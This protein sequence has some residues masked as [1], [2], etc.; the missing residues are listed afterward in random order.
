MPNIKDIAARAN[1]S[2][3]TVSYVLNG[4]KSVSEK[5]RARVLQIIEEMNYQPNLVAKSLKLK[6]TQTIGV[7]VEDVTSFNSSEIIDGIHEYAEEQGFSILLTNIRVLK[8]IDHFYS[9]ADRV[10]ELAPPAV[11]EIVNKQVDGLIYV[12][13]HPRDVTGLIPDMQIPIVYSYCYTNGA[14]DYSVNYDDYQAAYES[15][16]YLIRTGHKKIAVI[17]GVMDSVPTKDRFNG[18]YQALNDNNLIFD[19]ALIKTGDWEYESG[20]R[21]A[22]ELL[23]MSPCPDAILAMNDN[24]A[25]GA[26]SAC[27]SLGIKVPDDIS[28][29]GFDDREF[30]SYLT[31]SLTTMRLPL[32]EMGIEAI[33]TLISV[34]NEDSSEEHNKKLS[35]KLIER[36]SV[37]KR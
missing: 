10:K 18:Y 4:K 28:V 17:S 3:A 8:R 32:H 5:T 21:S 23:N 36:R 13:V 30:S 24:M 6:R 22:L 12:G 26:V 37:K 31:P 16:E 27:H 9:K 20:H 2:T 11:K 35:C 1:V 7:I 15:T 14:D 33:R 19:P 29:V 25:A 34:L